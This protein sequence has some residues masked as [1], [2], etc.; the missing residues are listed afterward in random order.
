M[1][2]QEMRVRIEKVM[3]RVDEMQSVLS[4]LELK[5]WLNNQVKSK[6]GLAQAQN[7]LEFSS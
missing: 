2:R 1:G 4:W 3:M 6:I 7:N 5:L